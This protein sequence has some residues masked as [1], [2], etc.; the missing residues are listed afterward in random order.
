M[1]KNI[2]DDSRG[3]VTMIRILLTL[4]LLAGMGRLAWAANV[5]HA[6][7]P[8]SGRLQRSAEHIFQLADRDKNG[9]LNPAEQADGDL[10]AERALRQLVHDNS[11][12][13]QFP[14][15]GVAEPQLA[16]PSAMT[17]PEFTEH[18]RALAADKDAALRASRVAR[19]QAPVLQPVIFPT[20]IVVS[21]GGGGRERDKDD[22]GRARDERSA[23]NRRYRQ[24]DR[25]DAPPQRYFQPNQSQAALPPVFSAPAPS[26]KPDHTRSSGTDHGSGPRH[27]TGPKHEPVTQ[28]EPARNDESHPRSEPQH[29]NSGHRWK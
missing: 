22:D 10:R 19:H 27:E 8:N 17:G 2:I 14:L 16:D 18:F 3:A 23:R 28:H 13:G 4:C 7:G 15:P 26:G 25:Y 24:D 12:G 20:P 21:G 9:T 1:T 29:N 11:I 6:P 5:V